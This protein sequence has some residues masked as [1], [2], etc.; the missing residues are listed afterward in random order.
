MTAPRRLTPRRVR[1]AAVGALTV[2]ALGA[3]VT[4]CAGSSGARSTDVTVLDVDLGR[5]TIEPATLTAEAG[6]LEL[7]VTNVDDELVHDL[8]VA[9]KGTKRLDPGQSQTLRIGEI[10]PG[11]YRMWCD[12]PGHKEAG[13]IGLLVVQAASIGSVAAGT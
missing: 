2:I 12:V 10:G 8:V 13:Q 3:T 7:R 4:S 11:E 1:R 6:E 9:G 5:F